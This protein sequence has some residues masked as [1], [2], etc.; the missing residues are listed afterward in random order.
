MRTMKSKTIYLDIRGGQHESKPDA[1]KAN[2]L[3]A[4]ASKVAAD[5]ECVA[6]LYVDTRGPYSGLAGVECWGVDQDARTYAGPR[7]LCLLLSSGGHAR[8]PREFA[9]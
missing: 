1:A 7:A 5:L 4:A 8:G 9:R 2:R 3:I 6:A